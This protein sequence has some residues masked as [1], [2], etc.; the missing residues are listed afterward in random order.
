MGNAVVVNAADLRDYALEPMLDGVS[1]FESVLKYAWKLPDVSSVIC[2]GSTRGFPSALAEKYKVRQV[3]HDTW[4]V[5]GLLNAMKE[6]TG[7]VELIFY[8][9]GDT[10]LLD[11]DLSEKMYEDHKRYFAQYSFADGYP[12]G[13]T[14]EILSSS[15]LPALLHLEGEEERKLDR[16]SIFT[17]IQKDINAFEIETALS[18]KDMRLLRISLSAD[19]KRNTMQLHSIIER[20]GTN[21]SS[22]MS[23]V[24]ESPE[25]LRSLPAYINIQVSGGCPQSCSYCP[26]PVISENCLENREYM[27]LGRFRK[28]IDDVS[29]FC[30]D[31]VIGVG[32]FGDPSLHP[33]FEGIADA[34]LEKASLSM[35]V[36]TSGI[37]WDR[38]IIQRLAARAAE[39][40]LIDRVTWIVS[41]DSLD[42]EVYRRLRGDGYYEA[43][44]T[45]RFLME[46]FPDRV[47]VQAVRMKENED[48][49][50]TFYREWKKETEHVIIQKYDTFCGFLPER[51]VADL[52]PVVRFPC[53]HIKRDL[54]VLLDGT[55]PL[56]REDLRC[57]YTLGNIFNEDIETIWARGDK[58]YREHIGKTYNELCEKCDEY[59][60]YNF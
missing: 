35:V 12:Y 9:F 42:Q 11:A 27:E 56:C 50:E 32:L 20:G 14:P 16:E 52:S 57:R 30:D 17:V 51:K 25:I 7:N 6:E 22:V 59:Y 45:V 15:L 43:L 2:I 21:A 39:R 23:V 24:D 5:S 28:L 60:T 1:S 4:T 55:V 58:V 18:P 53:W 36:E 19:T 3:K 54:A 44:K 31:A 10:P 49:L 8:V 40:G 48:V 47:W 33:D 37:G 29:A 38:D 34:V 46:H 13:L 26:Y 41:L